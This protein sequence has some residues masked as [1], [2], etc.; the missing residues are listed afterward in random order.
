MELVT[1][2]TKPLYTIR[3][4]S[5]LSGVSPGTIRE[6]ERQGLLRVYRRPQSRHR[7]FSA[8]EIRW[9]RQVWDL[10]HEAGL[11]VAGIR[12]LLQVEPCYKVIKCAKEVRAGCPVFRAACLPCWSHGITPSC[13]ESSGRNCQACAAYLLSHQNPALS[14]K[15]RR[16]GCEPSHDRQQD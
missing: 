5:E 6:Y 9:I 7:L 1:D 12:R 14:G 16:V 11:N 3:V 10:L 13:C 15:G 8:L 4:A 2:E